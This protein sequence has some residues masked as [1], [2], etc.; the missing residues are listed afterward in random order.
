MMR[1]VAALDGDE[2]HGWK[3]R[4]PILWAMHILK[5][6]AW[7]DEHRMCADFAPVEPADANPVDLPF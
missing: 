4:R 7:Y 6:R 1:S 5:L 2:G 3:S